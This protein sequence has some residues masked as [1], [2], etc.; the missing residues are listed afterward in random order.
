METAFQAAQ[1][2]AA[3]T[4]HM[5]QLAAQ[6]LQGR[7]TMEAAALAAQAMA[8]REAEEAGPAARVRIPLAQGTIS[9]AQA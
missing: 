8:M 4:N 9:K 2:E 6:A 5:R 3:E 7:A 1:E